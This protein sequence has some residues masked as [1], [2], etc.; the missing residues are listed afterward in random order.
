MFKSS[1]APA[2][3]LKVLQSGKKLTPKQIAK[4]FGVINPH[5]PVY[6][7]TEHGY[8]VDRKYKKT[9]QG[10]ETVTYSMAK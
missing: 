3:V 4:R 2:K 10:F 6:V 7:L 9:K 8:L 5:D 1:S